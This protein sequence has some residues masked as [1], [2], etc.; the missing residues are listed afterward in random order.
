MATDLDEHTL[1]GTL[2]QT[3]TAEVRVTRRVV[4][5]RACL[6]VRT[7]FIPAGQADMVPSR[8]GITIDVKKAKALAEAILR[9]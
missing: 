6:D 8:K 3:E 5:G 1:L 9:A 2:P 4:K 7:W